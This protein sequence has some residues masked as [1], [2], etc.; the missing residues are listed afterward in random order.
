MFLRFFSYNTLQ[1]PGNNFGKKI[2]QK[3]VHLSLGWVNLKEL[4]QIYSSN[5]WLRLWH[6]ISKAWPYTEREKK[7][8]CAPKSHHRYQVI[9]TFMHVH[10]TSTVVCSSTSISTKFKKY[11]LQINQNPIDGV[12]LWKKEYRDETPRNTVFLHVS[13][14]L[15]L[16]FDPP[17][18][19][20]RKGWCLHRFDYSRVF[21]VHCPKR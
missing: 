16:N 17:S 3:E 1:A 10:C 11:F 12:N 6:L 21:V 19:T 4:F 8:V 7:S 13:N 20:V 15:F 18:S 2:I 14:I 5:C 9:I